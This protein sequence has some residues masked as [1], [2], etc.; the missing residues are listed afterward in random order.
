MSNKFPLGFAYLRLRIKYASTIPWNNRNEQLFIYGRTPPYL[1]PVGWSYDLRKHCNIHGKK[2]TFII[3][4]AS[5]RHQELF[6]K[7]VWC[8]Y[9]HNLL[10]L[11]FSFLVLWTKYCHEIC[12]TDSEYYTRLTHYSR[13]NNKDF[14][15]FET[16]KSSDR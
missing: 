6:Y 16:F 13:F 2:Y 5:A 3:V 11:S 15:K 4:T 12:V 1:G 14:L 9:I 7:L 10:R 8:E